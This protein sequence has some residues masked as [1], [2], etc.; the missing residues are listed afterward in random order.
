MKERETAREKDKNARYTPHRVLLDVNPSPLY[1]LVLLL[2]LFLD[3]LILLPLRRRHL[4]ES[5]TKNNQKRAYN[6]K[7]NTSSRARTLGEV[8]GHS[9][10]FFLACL[11]ETSPTLQSRRFPTWT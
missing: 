6:C 2:H 7:L 4:Q 1:L 8:H 10:A 11:I 9:R 5:N 3:L